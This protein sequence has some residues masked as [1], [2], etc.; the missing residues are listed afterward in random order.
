MGSQAATNFESFEIIQSG[1]VGYSYSGGTNSTITVPH[2]LNYAPLPFV[3]LTDAD[4]SV[5]TPL[6]AWLSLT[7]G[8]SSI[9]FGVFAQASVDSNNLY[10]RTD[11]TS[12]SFGSGMYM[13]YYL[14]RERAS[15]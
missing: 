15:V 10:I 14:L 13:K 9:N 4:R 7:V 11:Y 1:N 2:N 8:A 5:F 6:P 12:G 3:F